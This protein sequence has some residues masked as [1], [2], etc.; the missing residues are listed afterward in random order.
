MLNP[1]TIRRL[2]ASQ[3]TWWQGSFVEHKQHGN[4]MAIS[5]QHHDK[6]RE[7]QKLNTRTTMVALWRKNIHFHFLISSIGSTSLCEN[8]EKRVD[9]PCTMYATME[10]AKRQE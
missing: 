2:I 1:P 3:M 8:Q 5:W 10:C 7:L 9:A 6:V 4:T